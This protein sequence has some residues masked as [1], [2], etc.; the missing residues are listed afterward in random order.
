[1]NNA[2]DTTNPYKNLYGKQLLKQVMF[3]IIVVF[4]QRF[5]NSPTTT[6]SFVLFNVWISFEIADAIPVSSWNDKSLNNILRWIVIPMI[7]G[8]LTLWLAYIIYF[9]SMPF[10]YSL[11][12]LLIA[13]GIDSLLAPFFKIVTSFV[14][15]VLGLLK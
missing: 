12:L 14:Y 10:R 3:A 13:L 5:F 11:S 1:M 6:I 4:L 7:T 8:A 9:Q 15:W 2:K